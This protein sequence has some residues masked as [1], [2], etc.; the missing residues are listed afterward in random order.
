MIRMYFLIK[1]FPNCVWFESMYVYFFNVPFMFQNH[2]IVMFW[3]SV[4]PCD[5]VAAHV[6]CDDHSV[7]LVHSLQ[8]IHSHTSRRCWKERIDCS[9]KC[10]EAD[11]AWVDHLTSI[12]IFITCIILIYFMV[13]WNDSKYLFIYISINIFFIYK[14]GNINCI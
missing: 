13:R 8:C 14:Y 3:G 1:T 6:R 2:F 7:H 12:G 4:G 11:L 10:D 9:S 5:T